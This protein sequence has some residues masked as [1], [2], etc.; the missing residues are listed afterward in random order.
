MAMVNAR[1]DGSDCFS[2]QFA[3][4]SQ[5][6]RSDEIIASRYK[7]FSLLSKNSL[8]VTDYILMI[9]FYSNG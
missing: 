1:N 2:I 4:A 6:T 5:I 8:E 3:H 9:L 7:F